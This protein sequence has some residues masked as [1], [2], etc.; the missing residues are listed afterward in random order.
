MAAAGAIS[1]AARSVLFSMPHAVVRHVEVTVPLAVPSH[2]AMA[3]A[4][5]PLRLQGH[6]QG[7][8]AEACFLGDG[9]CRRCLLGSQ[10]FV[11][12]IPDGGD[13]QLGLVWF[14]CGG[15]SCLVNTLLPS[16]LLRLC[17]IART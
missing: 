9:C 10:A 5:R 16:A 4:Y 6:C 7:S 3:S 11:P 1:A 13:T 17:L 14:G 2:G 15:P 12:Q 8:A